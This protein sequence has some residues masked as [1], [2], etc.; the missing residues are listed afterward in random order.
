MECVAVQ[1]HDWFSLNCLMETLLESSV[2]NEHINIFKTLE[3]SFFSATHY[4]KHLRCTEGHFPA[5]IR[6]PMTKSRSN[7]TPHP[8]RTF[9][10]CQRV[11]QIHR[12]NMADAASAGVRGSNGATHHFR[13]A[14]FRMSGVK[15]GR[16]VIMVLLISV[17][18]WAPESDVMGFRT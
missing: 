4:H 2:E 10:F 5:T 6:P 11:A 13:Y 8:W 1:T 16:C 14:L 3:L 7:V 15:R 18:N 17:T 12:L 9:S